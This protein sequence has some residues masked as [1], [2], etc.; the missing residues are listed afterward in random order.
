MVLRK[1]SKKGLHL[2]FE[3]FSPMPHFN[4]DLPLNMIEDFLCALKTPNPGPNDTAEM[5]NRDLE[6][7]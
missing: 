2:Y 6:K 5:H 4:V 1:A 7:S 3:L